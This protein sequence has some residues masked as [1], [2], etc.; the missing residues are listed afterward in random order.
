[1]ALSD[2]TVEG[3]AGSL[4]ARA[5]T[6][7]STTFT[8]SGWTHARLKP[9]VAQ[10]FP[11]DPEMRLQ[12]QDRADQSAGADSCVRRSPLAIQSRRPS[13]PLSSP[14]QSIRKRQHREAVRN[15]GIRPA[16]VGLTERAQHADLQAR[17][18]RVG[19]CGAERARARQPCGQGSA[20][21]WRQRT[22]T[23][24]QKRTL[25]QTS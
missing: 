13:R 9:A 18:K 23:T 6:L 15:Q 19:S 8:E 7:P 1:M 24:Q 10:I 4:D 20:F 14:D 25:R 17:I 16:K 12:L 2:H 5:C 21:D 3:D 22:S 11:G